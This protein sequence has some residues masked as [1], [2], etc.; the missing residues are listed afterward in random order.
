MKISSLDHLVLTVSDI[1]VTCNF[2]QTVLGME[3]I[4]F[5]EDRKALKFANQKFYLHQADNQF[6]PNT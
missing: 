6:E 2:Y 1:D 5:A 3:V 4:T